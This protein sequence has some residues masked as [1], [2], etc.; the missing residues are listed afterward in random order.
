[1]TSEMTYV[2]TASRKFANVFAVWLVI[3]SWISRT[4]STTGANAAAET[5]GAAWTSAMDAEDASRTAATVTT[6]TRRRTKTMN[7]DLEALANEAKTKAY[8]P[9]SNH[10]VGCAGVGRSG[11][12]YLGC[13]VELPHATQHA[14]Q[15]MLAQ[16]ALAGDVVERVY[17]TCSP[18][19]N[20]R[21][22]L[23]E[24][25]LTMGIKFDGMD[26]W[27]S[28][29]G[30]I[31][32]FLRE[33]YQRKND[34]TPP[35][36]VQHENLL[37][38]KANYAL[39]TCQ[40]YRSGVAEACAIEALDGR[41][42]AAARNEWCSYPGDAFTL[43]FGAMA[44]A[45][46]GMFMFGPKEVYFCGSNLAQQQTSPAWIGPLLSIVQLWPKCNVWFDDKRWSSEM[47]ASMAI[48]RAMR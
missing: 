40:A 28:D 38:D 43:A 26:H 2:T 25:N 10:Q 29:F 41:I 20:C 34:Y 37:I 14:E 22:A 19:G 13:N 15:V 3:R 39:S 8:C 23:Y 47:I 46:S 12:I 11:Q 4:E 30:N 33:A 48:Y 17:L 31:E 7:N 27:C 6:T 35:A 21:Q 16:A 45:Y 42:F 36:Y 44:L 9:K 18:C 32:Y 24:H 5:S 1:M